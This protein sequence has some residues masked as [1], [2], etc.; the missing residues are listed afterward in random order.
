MSVENIIEIL[1]VQLPEVFDLTSLPPGWDDDFIFIPVDS[2]ERVPKELEIDEDTL[3][4]P[5]ENSIGPN[6]SSQDIWVP[7][8]PGS[9]P[10]APISHRTS[11]YPP[12]DALAFYLPFHYFYPWGIYLIYEGV[13][14][15]AKIIVKESPTIAFKDAWKASQIYLY[16]HEAYHHN[17]ESFATKLEITHRFPLYKKG[18]REVYND[19]KVPPTPITPHEESLATAYGYFK[20]KKAFKSE[21]AKMEAILHGLKSYS[22]NLPKEYAVGNELLD[23]KIFKQGQCWFAEE[24]HFIS[25]KKKELLGEL[26]F[27]FP[28]AFKGIA[29]ITSKIKYIIR[30]DNPIVKLKKLHLRYFRRS[31]VIKKLKELFGISKVREGGEHEIWETK[32][33]KQLQFPRGTGEL[34]VGTLRSILKKCGSDMSI[35]KFASVKI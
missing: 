17:V 28:D 10:G 24:N 11:S 4:Q 34:K 14:E 23:D 1:H 33:G 29:R 2:F 19:K 3:F 22:N 7:N 13:R 5:Q 9:F 32:D 31:D 27:G 20:V 25:V 16:A 26:W 6:Y 30:S 8:I 12:P 15:L 21:S 18:F 35:S